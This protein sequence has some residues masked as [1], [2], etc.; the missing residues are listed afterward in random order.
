MFSKEKIILNGRKEYL[1]FKLYAIYVYDFNYEND[2]LYWL[3][4]TEKQF[5]P[6][7]RDNT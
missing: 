4:K 3:N 1:L 7:P 5:S 6:R 2:G